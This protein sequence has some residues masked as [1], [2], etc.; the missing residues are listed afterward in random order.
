MPKVDLI[1][2]HAD[3]LI[4]CAAPQ[5]VKHG[6]AMGEIGMILDGAVAVDDGRI[7]A[8]GSTKEVCAEYAA[9]Q[10]IDVYGHAV[11]PGLVDAH[12]HVVYAG[13]RI[14]EFEQRLLGKSYLEILEAGG[15]IL[16]TVRA[17]R[18]APLEELV[19]TARMR[20]DMMLALGT[21][22]AE[23]KTGYALDTAG[24]LKM[25]AA[26][27]ALAG[28][29]HS[30]AHPV[31]L[32][33]TFLGAHA[34]PPE[35]CGR[36]DAYLDEVI[37]PMLPT[38][39]AWY[40]DSSFAHHK[41]PLFCDVFCEKGVFDLQQSERV[42][43]AASTLGMLVKIHADEFSSL[44]GAALAVKLGAASADHLDVTPPEEIVQLA[45]SSTVGVL[46]PAVNFHL[47]SA[48]F[49]PARAMIDAGMAVALATDLNP[50]SAPCPSLPLVMAIACRYQ[51]LLPAEALNACTINAA[52]ALGLGDRIGSI[53]VGKQA[54][55]IILKQ[56]DY[57][58]LMY[59]F[60]ANPVAG[61]IKHGR[62]VV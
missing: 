51:Q 2:S 37:E 60:G 49:A 14:E 34:I 7:V 25:L 36:P 56:S 9:R 43:R 57:R 41:I 54:D 50:G 8:V 31:E 6:H 3:Q 40:R 26:I 24:E 33:P 39:M 52:Y 48:H 17:T 35:Y 55:L 32:V 12:T 15:G 44:G 30:P 16:T 61:V 10:Q 59:Q 28:D 29:G 46:L 1:V 47:G 23:V 21:T 45:A 5:G 42:L 27:A 4:T 22:T 53:E 18:A 19:A 58:H 62:Q 20:L 11:C 13:D 38:V